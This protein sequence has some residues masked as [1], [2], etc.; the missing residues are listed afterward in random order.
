MISNVLNT[1]YAE[2][3]S[4]FS[5]KLVMYIIVFGILPSIYIIKVKINFFESFKSFKMFESF[6]SE[7]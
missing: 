5:L 4:F 2:S 1:D 7:T 3:S 6:N